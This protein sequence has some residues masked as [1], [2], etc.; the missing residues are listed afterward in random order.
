[1]TEL[2]LELLDK[3][4]Y[5]GIFV[6]MILENVFPPVPSEVILGAAGVLVAQGKMN[7]YVLWIIATVGTVVGN[8]FWYWLGYRWSEETLKRMIDRWGRILTFE[9][10]EFTKARDIFRKY[11]DWIVF[12]LRFSPL[13][14][15][16]VSLPAGLARMGVW[17]FSMFTFLGSLIWNGLLILGGRALS[18]L[19]EQYETA[20]GYAIVALVLAGVAVYVYRFVTWKPVAAFENNEDD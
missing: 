13:L 3:G 16:I 7:G 14:R 17:R 4:G 5:L 18:G 10:D 12:L 19:I 9:W 11:G 8:L 6:L 20:A 15:T 1:M 2:L